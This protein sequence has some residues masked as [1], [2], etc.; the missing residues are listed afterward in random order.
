MMLQSERWQFFIRTMCG[1]AY[2]AKAPLHDSDRDDSIMLE[3]M[4]GK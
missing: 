1:D 4:I 3:G 2:G